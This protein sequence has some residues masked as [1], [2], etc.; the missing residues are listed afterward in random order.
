MSQARWEERQARLAAVAEAFRTAALATQCSDFETAG[1]LRALAAQWTLQEQPSTAELSG[2]VEALA[3]GSRQKVPQL[4]L[5]QREV[6][7]EIKQLPGGMREVWALVDVAAPAELVW[8]TLTDY[9]RLA[10]IVPS[11]DENR[12]LERWAGGVRLQQVAAQ[13]LAWGLKFS[14]TATLNIEELPNGI[15]QAGRK[16]QPGGGQR[17]IVPRS[18]GV[19]PQS[20]RDIC[21]SLV[22]SRDLKRFVG[23]WRIETRDDVRSRL[24]Y[25]VEVQPQPWLPVGAS[26]CEALASPSMR[27]TRARCCRS[28][29]GAHGR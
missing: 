19:A 16:G 20:V 17:R 25:V 21:F 15:T 14:A 27:L 6:L 26:V 28:D 23:T 4:S 22:D 9:E 8:R 24:I 29:C 5:A 1:K 13:E 2:T 7:V 12:V 11:L 18:P 3:N 10:D